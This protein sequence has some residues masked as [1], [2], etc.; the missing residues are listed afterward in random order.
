MSVDL[1]ILDA[2]LADRPGRWSLGV[3][4]DRI[5]AV[6]EGDRL[7]HG[8]ARAVVQAGGRLLS[9]TLVDAHTHL[10]KCFTDDATDGLGRDA[11]LADVVA[12]MRTRK[13][14]FDT[15]D[16]ARRAGRA[17]ISSLAAGVGAMRTN[18]D[19]DAIVG[20]DA[21]RGVRSAAT[22]AAGP[23]LQTVAFPQ[24]GWFPEE[25]DGRR[26][27]REAIGAGADV[28]G[29]NV[30]GSLWASSPT[31]QIDELLDLARELDRPVDLHLDNTDDPEA[32]HLPALVAAVAARS[33]AGRVTVSHAAALAAVDDRSAT[34]AIEAC[35]EAG[36]AVVV[37][38]TRVRLTRW[39]A[40][41]DAGVTVA[42]GTDNLR[43]AFVSVGDGDPVGALRLLAMLGAVRSTADLE[44]LWPLVTTNPARILELP[45]YGIDVGRRADLV[46]FEAESVA[47][48]IRSNPARVGVWLAGRLV[49]GT[50]ATDRPTDASYQ[51]RGGRAP[52]DAAAC[53]AT[54][55]DRSVRSG[56]FALDSGRHA[57]RFF[58]ATDFLRGDP[59]VV[60][61]A[62]QALAAPW[63]DA[64][65]DAVLGANAAGS[66]L[67][68]ETSRR[69]G[70]TP[71][72]A[73]REAGGYRLLGS[74][75]RPGARVL[76]VDDVTTTGG[77]AR[78]LLDAA[79]VAGTEPI[80]L[81]LLATKGVLELDLSIPVHVVSVLTGM[82]SVEPEH[83]PQCADAVP[84]VS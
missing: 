52:A 53:T 21:L 40:L 84:L 76:V 10:D 15:T 70:A 19:V 20:L 66:V 55:V 9:P 31:A 8:D 63:T 12:A 64:H 68:Y 54:L 37:N 38:P 80:G 14:A 72:F 1:A 65:V 16:V 67:A 22:D 34:A 5:V 78:Q 58:Q 45:D 50:L 75:P 82:D 43:D 13:H 48:I 74:D 71:L 27:V 35:A 33:T 73:R 47:D 6:D 69:L 2:A 42:V 17:L 59:E 4:G 11:G 3:L 7:C 24:E 25:G 56:H 51:R 57:S 49:A 39:R 18:V 79:A 26:W 62:L 36:V 83:C 81:G 23:M 60:E 46:L 28:V 29:G 44:S 32:F 30:N 41:I 77:T 61:A